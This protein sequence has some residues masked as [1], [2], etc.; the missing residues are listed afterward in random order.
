[1]STS[2]KV[3]PSRIAAFDILYR[4]EAAGA[5]ASNLLVSN[6]HDD[7]SREDRA[8]LNEL[9]LGVL[10]WRG[11]LDFLIELYSKREIS[12]I[13]LEVVIALRLGLY[14]MRYLTRVPAHAAINES[15]NL[16]KLHKKL[17]A[18]SMVNAV[19]RSAQR[20][21]DTSPYNQI[22][23]PVQKL[24]VE[25]SHPVW[26]V[27]KWI[28]RFGVDETRK[29]ALA[30][31]RGPRISFR[32]KSSPATTREWFRTYNIQTQNS[33]IAP[34]AEVI[35]SGG[36]TP[37]SMPV[38][39]GWI[40]LQDEASQLVAHLAAEKSA[41]IALDLCAAPG[42]KT[43]LLASLLGNRST[44]IACD[45][46]LHRLK[47]MK[48]IIDRFGH[49]R[50][51]LVQMDASLDLPFAE[52]G[53]FDTVLLDA[54]CSGLGTLQ[55]NPE[56]KW[57]VNQ[58]KIDEL[59]RLQKRLIAHAAAQVRSGGLLIYAVCS[60]EPEEG[61]QIIEWFKQQHPE[62]RD[63]TGERLTELGISP[64]KLLTA[65][66]GARTFPHIHGTEGFFFCVLWKRTTK[67]TE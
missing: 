50:I 12:K 17:S 3:S 55:R 62:F 4:V 41:K 38:R 24:A 19:L 11:S 52:P 27:E 32:F 28:E 60:T 16:M 5:Y 63:M 8:L 26:L 61:E 1:M 6:R 34:A 7:L 13:D 36:F 45:I 29:L 67:D 22:K 39:E 54:P 56:I 53:K 43:T 14:Q 51:H 57:R 25:T 30:N 2:T 47:A 35:R 21:A 15:V 44:V 23:D 46:H 64:D 49:A 33:V 20:D 42:G 65:S 10:R 58:K 40:Y 37:D 59:S 9:T 48:E 66:S 18:A 31:N